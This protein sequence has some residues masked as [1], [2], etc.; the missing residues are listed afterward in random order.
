M[1]PLR[2]RAPFLIVVCC[3]LMEA[4]AARSA[5][6]AVGGNSD[7]KFEFVH[8]KSGRS[9][10]GLIVEDAPSLIRFQYVKRKPG[11]KTL[12]IHT[13]FARDE[14]ARL[15]RLDR[16]ERDRLR[17]KLEALDATGKGERQW[18][19]VLDLKPVAWG[20]GDKGRL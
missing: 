2:P 19:D 18:M 8:L 4:A 9:F 17:A 11:Q 7:W 3:A 14:V 13:T 16:E 5:P 15:T 20:A 6:D 12:V 1:L 10:P